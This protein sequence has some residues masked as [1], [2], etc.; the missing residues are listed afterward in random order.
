MIPWTIN[1]CFQ[2]CS[3]GKAFTKTISFSRWIRSVLPNFLIFFIC[4]SS[5]AVLGRFTFKMGIGLRGKVAKNITRFI[6]PPGARE[7]ELTH[8][9]G[10]GFRTRTTYRANKTKKIEKHSCIFVYLIKLLV[11]ACI[12]L[13]SQNTWNRLYV[14][15]KGLVVYWIEKPLR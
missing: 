5:L 1:S 7:L 4:L 10:G 13:S 12:L 14:K 2:S 3:S 11:V 9:V 8:N 15:K 6:Y